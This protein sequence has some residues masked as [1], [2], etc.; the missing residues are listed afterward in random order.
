MIALQ[1]GVMLLTH[2][3]DDSKESEVNGIVKGKSITMTYKSLTC[4]DA[5]RL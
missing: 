1:N 5:V 4:C 3:D 2:L